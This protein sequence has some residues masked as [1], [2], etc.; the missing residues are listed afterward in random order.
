MCCWIFL[1]AM[2]IIGSVGEVRCAGIEHIATIVVIYPE[3]R[4]FDTLYGSFPGANGLSQITGARYAQ[5]N[6]DG[7]IGEPP[8]GVARA[9]GQQRRPGGDPGSRIPTV[10][11]SSFGGRGL[12]DHTLYNTT[13]ILRSNTK[14]GTLPILAGL[15]ACDAAIAANGS[16]A[17]DLTGALDLLSR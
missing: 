17:G 9:D 8:P 10:I 3:N 7:S 14:R 5:F 2:A 15:M 1:S 6:R 12:V 4:S 13:S 11:V 16:L